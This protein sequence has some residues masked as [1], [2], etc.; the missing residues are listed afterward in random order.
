MDGGEKQLV[1]GSLVEKLRTEV[2]FRS[3]LFQ[4]R[5]KTLG[6]RVRIIFFIFLS[7]K[8]VVYLQNFIERPRILLYA[9][10]QDPGRRSRDP[11]ETEP[12][13]PVTV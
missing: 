11:I 5:T 2:R 3:L 6:W 13:L 10:H 9:Q 8:G 12:D 4:E 7:R 1:S